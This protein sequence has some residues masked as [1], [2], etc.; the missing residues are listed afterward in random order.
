MAIPDT[1][2]NRLEA[3]RAS[4]RLHIK[5]A[6]IF[7]EE[8]WVSVLQGQGIVPADYHPLADAISDS[9]LSTLLMRLHTLNEKAVAAMPRHAEFIAR[10]CVA[11]K[12]GKT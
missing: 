4:G 3:Y 8:S 11:N 2:E 7:K 1:L 6:D 10:Y 5:P 12:S 9:D